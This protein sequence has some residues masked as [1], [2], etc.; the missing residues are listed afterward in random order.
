MAGWEMSKRAGPTC[1][2][3]LAVSSIV[4]Y[5][6]SNPRV[7]NAYGG[8]QDGAGG[9]SPGN[10]MHTSLRLLSLWSSDQR[11][12]AKRL[13]A[14]IGVANSYGAGPPPPMR[15]FAS[16]LGF[17]VISLATRLHRENSS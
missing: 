2:P 10:G 3:P 11:R 14:E 16:S 1:E 5:D 12:S 15:Y 7:G 9:S 8:L 4:A 13:H 17:R 6:L